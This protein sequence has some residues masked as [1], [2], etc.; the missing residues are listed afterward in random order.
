MTFGRPGFIYVVVLIISFVIVIGISTYFTSMRQGR[1]LAYRSL[2]GDYAAVL[3]KAGLSMSQACLAE[4][5]RDP[6]SPIYKALVQPLETYMASGRARID[7]GPRIDLSSMFSN[8]VDRISTD[9]PRGRSSVAELSAQFYIV[10]SQLVPLPALTVG[11]AKVINRSGGEKMGRIFVECTATVSFHAFDTRVSRTLAGFYEFRVVHCPIPILSDFTLFVRESAG[12]FNTVEAGDTGLQNGGQPAVVLGNGAKELQSR[13]ADMLNLESL[14]KQGW[15]YLGGQNEIVL[16]LT[17]SMD[18]TASPSQVGEDFHFYQQ[19]PSSLAAGRAVVD[20]AQKV[21]ANRHLPN[22][23]WE[24]RNWDMGVNLLKDGALKAQYEEVFRGTSSGYRLGSQLK[25]LGAPPER[26]SPTLVFGP[27][28]AGFFRIVAAAPANPANSSFDAYFSVLKDPASP[29]DPAKN[30]ARDYYDELQPYLGKLLYLYDPYKSGKYM[31][32]DTSVLGGLLEYAKGTAKSDYLKLCAG[33]RT[34]NYNQALLHLKTRNEIPNPL[35]HARE[36]GIPESLFTDPPTSPN[37]ST[38]PAALLPS[39][40]ADLG[41]LD[42]SKLNLKDMVEPLRRAACWAGP[43]SMSTESYLIA[44]RRLSGEELDLGTMICSDSPLTL[45]A[46]TKVRRGGIIL[47]PSITLQ[48][49]VPAAD[50]GILVLVAYQGTIQL[51]QAPVHA[52]LVA[53]NGA[54]VANGPLD[55][56]GNIVAQ[57]LDLGTSGGSSPGK[58]D[59]DAAKLKNRSFEIGPS[60]QV[61]DTFVID[62]S[63]RVTRIQ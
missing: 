6:S 2:H 59:Y 21:L 33:F 37:R 4:A 9:L 51:P 54:V 46:L 31:Y 12:L 61:S 50:R 52:S 41:D 28:S 39:A 38:L 45:P 30:F 62:F 1:L 29:S 32:Y 53:T 23:F 47:A 42:L 11:P 60:G 27:V 25:L 22:P 24:V 7:V 57:R 20:P 40:W 26:V 36:F 5:S 63:R 56:T 34:R 14:K 43:K 19:N 13:T 3:A 17:Y 8:I 35:S 15:V 44:E 49:A 16:N 58:L 18:E 48:G 55:V 10:P